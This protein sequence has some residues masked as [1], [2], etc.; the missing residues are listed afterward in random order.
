MALTR[1]EV[2]KVAKLSM[3]EFKESEVV[4]LQNELNDILEFVSKLDEAD[5][6]G[7]EPMTQVNDIYNSFRED[8]ITES[9]TREEAVKNAPEEIEGTFAVPRTVGEN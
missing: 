2:L 6:E 9:L 3:L 1:E 5:V 7:I 4:V 8:V